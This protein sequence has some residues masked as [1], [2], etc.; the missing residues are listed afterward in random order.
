MINDVEDLLEE[1]KDYFKNNLNARITAINTEKTAAGSAFTIDT[2]PA[3][4]EHYL[5]SGQ[6]RE[7]PNRN[8]VNVSISGEPEIENNHGNIKVTAVILVEVVTPNN[9]EQKTYFKS[10]R[11]LRAVYETAADFEES[12]SEVGSLGITGAVPMETSYNQRELVS[13]GVFI[14]VSIA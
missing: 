4:D 13:S 7:I 10:W 9:R 1:I 2:I 8:F 14:S 12:A 3:N 6:Y 11:Y 5:I